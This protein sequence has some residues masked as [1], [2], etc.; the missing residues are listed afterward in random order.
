MTEKSDL[1]HIPTSSSQASE[2]SAQSSPE[3]RYAV[4][5]HLTW[6]EKREEDRRDKAYTKEQDERSL[7]LEDEGNDTI[8]KIL[9]AQQESLQKE[10]SQQES[11]QHESFQH[12]SLPDPPPAYAGHRPPHL[13]SNRSGLR[14][15]GGAAD[16]PPH[17]A[18]N[19][20]GPGTLD[21]ALHHQPVPSASPEPGKGEHVS[22]HTHQHE[23]TEAPPTSDVG[24]RRDEEHHKSHHDANS[25]PPETKH[26]MPNSP[27][28]PGTVSSYGGSTRFE[29]PLLSQDISKGESPLDVHEYDILEGEFLKGD[30]LKGVVVNNDTLGLDVLKSDIVIKT[31]IINDD[32]LTKEIIKHRFQEG[33][34]LQDEILQV[35]IKRLLFEHLMIML[36]WEKWKTSMGVSN[37]NKLFVT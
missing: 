1:H 4:P 25:H 15:S 12:E 7:E 32:M 8:N 37:R 16:H 3:L 18:S 10:S 23:M 20:S 33:V 6:V 13:A 9:E 24:Q 31:D 34:I 29:S 30:I 21:G 11:L 36:F 17:L 26:E 19:G 14:I 28:T 27:T 35:L 2:H 22:H 5:R